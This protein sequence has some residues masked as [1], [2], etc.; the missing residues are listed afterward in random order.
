MMVILNL[1][2]AFC[3]PPLGLNLF[4]SSFRFQRPV[5]SLY[6]SVMPFVGLLALALGIVMAVPLVSTALVES[7]I[8]AAREAATSWAWRRARRGTWSACSRISLNPQP[9]LR[10]GERAVRARGRRGDGRTRTTR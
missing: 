1:E 3:T 9:L 5:A 4:I 10:G 8:R 6:R 7:D 2:L